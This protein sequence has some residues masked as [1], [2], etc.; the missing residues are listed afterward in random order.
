MSRITLISSKVNDAIQSTDLKKAIND[1]Y[2]SM[3]RAQGK[4]FKNI[5]VYT[6]AAYKR[7]RNKELKLR[8]ATRRRELKKGKKSNRI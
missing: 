6:I 1:L 7:Q 5:Y 3:T 4:S 2:G 8:Y